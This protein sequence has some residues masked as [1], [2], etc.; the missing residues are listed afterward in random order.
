MSKLCRAPIGTF[1]RGQLYKAAVL[2]LLAVDPDIWLVDEPFA[3]GM[4]PQGILGFKRHAREAAARGKTILYSTQII[5]IAEEFCDQ[6]LILDEHG[7]RAFDR[8]ENLRQNGSLESRFR[9]QQG[10]P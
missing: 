1:S 4:D 9:A 10:P 2:G 3:S 6:L 5:E 8:P 7:V